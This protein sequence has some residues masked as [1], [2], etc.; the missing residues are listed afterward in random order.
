MYRRRNDGMTEG[1][2]EGRKEGTQPNQRNNRHHPQR[3]KS[4]ISSE[5]YS[6]EYM[7]HIS[8]SLSLSLSP[9]P[10]KIQLQFSIYLP[11]RP[12]S[13]ASQKSSAIAGMYVYIYESSTTPFQFLVGSYSTILL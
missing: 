1:R 7:K 8:L 2:K 9:R 3:G 5:K 13:P 11:S 10:L 12:L 4:I 6:I